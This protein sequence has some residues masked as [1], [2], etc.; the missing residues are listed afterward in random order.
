MVDGE[1]EEERGQK[2]GTHEVESFS[3]RR[4]DVGARIL[5]GSA[6]S[7]SLSSQIDLI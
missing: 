2:K 1:D 5:N 3:H 7:V 6:P 4:F